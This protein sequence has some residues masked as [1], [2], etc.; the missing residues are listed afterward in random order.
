MKIVHVGAWNRNWGDAA[1]Q[2]A[3]RIA[4]GDGHEW[5]PFDCQTTVFTPE[6]VRKIESDGPVVWLIGGGGLIWAKPELDSVSGW[7]WQITPEAME[8]IT[9]KVVVWALGSPVFP[10]G[11]STWGLSAPHAKAL[12]ESLHDVNR[13][14]TTFTVRGES[15]RFHLLNRLNQNFSIVPDIAWALV[16]HERPAQPGDN[17]G[18]LWATD[19]QYWRWGDSFHRDDAVAAAYDQLGD[20]ENVTHIRHLAPSDGEQPTPE[21]VGRWARKAYA[22]LRGVVSTRKH[23]I[24]IGAAM[25]VPVVGLGDVIEV[26]E[27]CDTI[28][29]PVVSY[30]ELL[31]PGVLQKAIEEAVSDRDFQHQCARIAG[32]TARE[33]LRTAI[34]KA[35][36]ET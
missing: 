33:G 20:I 1:I 2:L 4:V 32:A 28:G 18:F 23:G 10:Y 30:R 21:A 34:T 5:L 11:D 26:A 36:G 8:A 35:W 17:I 16:D 31:V 22:G 6:L 25:G 29:A 19:K 14:A 24:I 15:T 12:T 9:G 27:I 3:C 13:K 7:Q